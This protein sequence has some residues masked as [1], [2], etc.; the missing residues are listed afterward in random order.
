M[1]EPEVVAASNGGARKSAADGRA[2]TIAPASAVGSR[3]GSRSNSRSGSRIGSRADERRAEAL[4]ADKNVSVFY[5]ESAKKGATAGHAPS[6]SVENDGSWF[7]ASRRTSAGGGGGEEAD[8]AEK[9]LSSANIGNLLG[10]PKFFHK[11]VLASV[12][13]DGII[14]VQVIAVKELDFSIF[15]D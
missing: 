2:A 12:W 8:D 15:G 13:V 7:A 3:I 9:R 6:N 10:K 5:A 11:F 4:L 14:V 1:L